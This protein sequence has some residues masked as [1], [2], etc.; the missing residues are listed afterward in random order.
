MTIFIKLISMILVLTVVW[1]GCAKRSHKIAE[2]I[3]IPVAVLKV[4]PKV[5][6][7][8]LSNGFRYVIRPNSKPENRSELRLVVDVGSV[9][10]NEDQQGLAHFVEHM[11]FNGT[12]NF[13]KQELVD[14][15]ELV[16]MR[17]GP[18]LN[19]YTSFDETVYML[20]IPMD[21]TIVI[22]TAMQ[23]LLDWAKGIKFESK[24][25]DKER[26]VVVEEW[27][28]GRG[29]NR[30]M[31]DQQLPVILRGSRYADRLPIGQK[32]VL[33]TFSH[34]TLRDFYETWYRPELMG[35][36]AVGQF[37]TSYMESLAIKYFSQIPVSDDGMDRKYH[38]VPNHDETL[39]A[40]ASDIEA[41]S[42]IINIYTKKEVSEQLSYFSYRKSIVERLYHHMFNERLGELTRQ[43]SPPFLGAGSSKGRLLRT[44]EFVSLGAAVQNNGLET[45]LEALLT[46]SERIKQHGFTVS[47]L[48]RA[49]RLL[50]RGIEQAY[51]ERDKIPSSS[52]AA[53][54]VR[55]LLIDEP[56]PGIE[57]EYRMYNEF[58]PGITLNEVNSLAS[59]WNAG[60]NRV[61][62][63]DAPDQ[64]GV[65]IPSQKDLEEIFKSVDKKT[66]QPYNDNFT[67]EP[68]IE[69]L[70]SR[71][72]VVKKDTIPELDAQIWTLSN[73]IRVQLK[74]TDFKNDE[75]LFSA[76]SEGGH[77]LVEDVDYISAATATSLVLEGGI[78]EFDN[79]QLQKKLAGKVV[80]VNPI[81]STY[82]EGFAGSASPEDLRTMFD[83]IYAYATVP[84]KDTTAFAAFKDRMSGSIENR[85]M[86]PETSF[87]DTVQVTMASQHFRARPWSLK[88][89]NEMDLNRSFSIYRERFEDMGDFIF[90]F[91]G[92]FDF[93]EMEEMSCAYLANLPATGRQETWRD[94]EISVPDSVVEKFVYAGMEPKSSNKII[95]TGP[96]EYDGWKNNFIIEALS[97]CFQIKLR[98]ILREDLGGTYSV[99]VRS[100]VE[101]FPHGQYRI[102][103]GFNCDP[104]RENELTEIVFS[105][106]D[107]LRENGIEQIYLEKV[108]EIRRRSHELALQENSF[109]LHT[110]E[111]IQ[112]HS[113]RPDQVTDY[114][115]LVN[116][117]N[118]E[119]IQIAAKQYFNKSQYARFVLYPRDYYHELE[120]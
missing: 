9:L 23:I 61:V 94:I 106:I 103:I 42:N 82:Q 85:E 79:I 12:E 63:I 30:R 13:H 109:W 113:I 105:Q 64:K 91:V 3:K 46:E 107:Y 25:I 22:D 39:F 48:S 16:G 2:E 26:G 60:S 31:F 77:S 51:R 58:L 108:K 114:S 4:D 70:P 10:E 18:D 84:R 37:E 54:Y 27:R 57:Q 95:F 28:L 65:Y 49:K 45:G 44:K 78:G 55:H 52:L 111:Q 74:Q 80:S 56:I 104:A 5:T 43:V 6:I 98:E 100:S 117:L 40:I 62:T 112:L 14:Y 11:A 119:Q 66:L 75:V 29:A 32:A 88:I 59:D 99:S 15:L 69:K 67:D 110:L 35:F 118:S 50:L 73:G 7:G 38:L 92:N 72:K 36:V 102:T 33:D 93:V 20:Q 1:C 89:L 115:S 87:S 101:H 17:F 76:F 97:A 24:E 96:F 86:R 19:A 120:E 21:S 53:E 41:T 47:E 8:K 81:L 90:S 71:G 116:G 68:L 34:E 83:L